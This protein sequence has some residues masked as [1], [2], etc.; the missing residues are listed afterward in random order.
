MPVMDM[1][2]MAMVIMVPLVMVTKGLPMEDI[3]KLTTENF[4]IHLTWA[5]RNIMY[6]C[7]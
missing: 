2:A 5:R 1:V 7:K 6:N 4:T 3:T